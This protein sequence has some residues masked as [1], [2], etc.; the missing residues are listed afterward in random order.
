MKEVS[1]FFGDSIAKEGLSIIKERLR[2][3]IKT[4]ERALAGNSPD[5]RAFASLPFAAEMPDLV[6]K[7]VKE[8]QALKPEYV[9]LIGIGGSSLGASAVE[10]A[11]WKIA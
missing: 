10:Q 8:K 11:R 4:M 6:K 3:E 9:V 2:V 5:G 1:F 7:L